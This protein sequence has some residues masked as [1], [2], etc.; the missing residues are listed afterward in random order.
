[1]IALYAGQA[2]SQFLL[3]LNNAWPT[4]PF[5][6]ASILL[7][8][9]VI[10]V[11]LTQIPA[12]ALPEGSVMRLP[13][14]Y[15]ASPLGVVGAAATGVM[16]G[17]FYGVGA[18]FAKGIGLN[19]A[20]T[21]LFMSAT[22][23]GGLA[24]QWPLGRLSDAIDRRTVIVVTILVTLMVCF[25][26]VA[27]AENRGQ[28]MLGGALFGGA[29][30]ALYPLCVAHTNDHLR[31]M[32]RVAASGG[33]V[34]VYSIGAVLGPLGAAGFMEL[35]GPRG[36]FLFIGSCA[37]LLLG[38]ATLRLRIGPPVPDSRQ[39]PYQTLPRTTPVAAALDP[40]MPAK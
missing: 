12:P 14:L 10:P 24:L 8:L 21:A 4:I 33:L 11:A 27:I 30:F 40:L 31:S 17:A 18:V 36:L 25:G 34:L 32:Q 35:F 28:M 16:L 3:N 5:I 9:A 7:S 20:G 38:F 15:R 37:A 6:A 1:M 26:M 39:G 22:I 19:T 23:L 2:V 29:C 13:Q